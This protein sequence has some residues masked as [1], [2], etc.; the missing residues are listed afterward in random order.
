[1]TRHFRVLCGAVALLSLTVS[2]SD[3]HGS[4]NKCK[5]TGN[6]FS[7]MI[8]LSLGVSAILTVLFKWHREKPRRLFAVWFRDVFKQVIGALIAHILNLT[9]AIILKDAGNPC[10]W[11]FTNYTIDTV[12]GVFVSF[13]L[14][15]LVTNLCVRCGHER[16]M[17]SGYYGDPPQ[18]RIWAL[19]AIVWCIIVI[20]MKVSIFGIIILPLRKYL[21]SAGDWVLS[22]AVHDPQIELV[23]VMVIA[24]VI[25]NVV[26]FWIQD[27]FLMADEKRA[28]E[29]Q[30][31]GADNLKDGGHDEGYGKL[32]FQPAAMESGQSSNDY[33]ASLLVV[34]EDSGP[35][36]TIHRHPR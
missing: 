21:I 27:N 29:L 26:Q 32:E 11:Y 30:R 1:M 33:R 2:A 31:S 16:L 15:R 7:Y 24:P 12:L 10:V 25:F 22:P 23:I 36:T 28:A 34:N 13:M 17:E 19:Q 18:N 4:E 3:D 8:Q 14:L 9:A 20:V 35:R 6:F 5:I